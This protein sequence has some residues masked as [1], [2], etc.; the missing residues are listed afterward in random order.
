MCIICPLVNLMQKACSVA[1]LY[2]V[3]F[4]IPYPFKG[5]VTLVG[6][7]CCILRVNVTQYENCT[8]IAICFNFSSITF[9]L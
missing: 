7:H 2:F 8:C 4:P 6:N 9:D 1:E 3:V 5:P